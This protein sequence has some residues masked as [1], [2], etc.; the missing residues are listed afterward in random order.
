MA[1]TTTTTYSF[2]KPEL[3]GSDD[4]WGTKLN[5]NLDTLD[6][7]LDGGAQISP[8]L[9][10]LEIDGTIVTATP[11]EL[12][13]VDGVTSAIQTQL[14]AKL[15]TSGGTDL[16]VADGGTGASDA[17]TAR[18][19]IGLAI[20][21]DVQAYDVDTVKKDVTNTFTATQ[22]LKGITETE[23][24]NS[25][26]TY[27][28]DLAN[29]TIFDLTSASAVTITMPTA[30]AGKAFTI[31]VKTAPAWSG[32]ILW[33]SATVPSA[34]TISIYSFISDGSSWYGMEAGNGFA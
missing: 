24:T 6:N 3:D 11:A 30:A 8:D 19:N 1:D 13:Y 31:I 9:T 17:S 29:G 27:T 7:L 18:T 14:D 21:T 22:T 15:A 33:A 23:A 12:N 28:V 10:D 25:T 32:T 34:T 16:A 26:T 2:T 4:T 20:G 5:T